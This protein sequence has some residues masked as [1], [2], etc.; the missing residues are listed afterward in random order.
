MHALSALLRKDQR[1]LRNLRRQLREQSAFKVAFILLFAGGMLAGLW[2]LFL[3]GFRFLSAL[4]GIGVMLIHH[5]FALFFFGLGLML[6]LSNIITTYTT[7]FH[8]EEIPFLLCRPITPGEMVLHKWLETT[9]LSSWAFFF[10]IIPFIGAFAWYERLSVFFILWTFLFSI[11]F[12]LLYA[13]VGTLLTLMIL[14]W[15]PRWR[16]HVWVGVAFL[17]LIG[18]GVWMLVGAGQTKTNDGAFILERFVPGLRLAAFPLWP[19]AW[20]AEGIMALSRNQ[21]SRG[22]LLFGVLL[23][24]VLLVG[25][26]IEGVGNAWFVQAWQRT[27]ASGRRT[28]RTGRV[29]VLET[30]LAF[31]APDTR[32]LVVK[33][34]HTLLRDPAQWIQGLLFFG[35][36]ALYFFN[37]RN[38]HYHLLSAV[39]RNLIVFL[40]M[41]SLSAV[42]C[43][44]CSRFIYPQLSLEGQAFWLIGLAPT[45]MGRVL[46]IKFLSA[47]VG[48]LAISVVLMAV[49]TALL[50]V[51]WRVWVTAM[52]L[53]VAISLGLCGLATGLGAVFLDLKQRNPMVII[54]GFGGTL[55]LVL[56]LVYMAA[57]ILPFGML[58]HYYTLNR[59][60]INALRLGTAVAVAWL[61]GI[62]LAAVFLPLVAGRRSLMRRDY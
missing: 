38:F 21:W 15:A 32:A 53:A 26:L 48:M 45:T 9:L 47:L 12:V 59:I 11:P 14:R 52:G 41:F 31:L 62:T 28:R 20:V 51:G 55:N 43:S 57:A 4:G 40:N 6:I 30:R 29:L 3:D 54:S 17:A 34:L 10:I 22:V 58:Y 8:S 60:G 13:G 35:L 16:P 27:R 18:W 1:V 23:A 61:I 25:L 24:N 36:L 44:F 7:A 33:D 2:Y 50:D 39:W 49:S 5:L 37:L 42:M 46:K 56:S 19:S